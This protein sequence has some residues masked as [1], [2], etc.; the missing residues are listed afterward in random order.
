LKVLIAGGCGFIGSHAVRHFV[1]SGDEVSVIDKLTYA[2]DKGRL[3]GLI[4][5]DDFIEGDICNTHTLNLVMRAWAPDVVV[6]FAAETHVDNS[7]KDATPFV[8]TNFEGACALM[9]ACRGVGALYVHLST[10]EVYGDALGHDRGFTTFDALRP[11]NPYSATKAAADMM[12]LANLN[13]YKQDFLAFRPSNNYGPNQHG[14]KFLPKLIDCM[15][16]G[17]P[18]PLYGDGMQMRE[19]TYAGDTARGIRDTI[20]SGVRN[21]FFN[22]TSGGTDTN[23]NI[24]REVARAIRARGLTAHDVVTLSTDRPGH[25]RRYWIQNDV[26]IPYTSFTDGLEKTLDHYVGSVK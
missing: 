21:R 10:D 6:N 8:K 11:R 13:T 12:L 7:I 26:K 22:L 5:E 16:T 15:L 18:F 1:E 19:W 4:P 24:T 3:E 2:A 14:E 23:L 9:T 20:V 17:K 25:D